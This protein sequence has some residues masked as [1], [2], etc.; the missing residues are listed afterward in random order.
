VEP[1]DLSVEERAR[2]HAALDR[3]EK[4]LRELQDATGYDTYWKLYFLL[5]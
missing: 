3:Q 1:V 5:S 2:L 4:E